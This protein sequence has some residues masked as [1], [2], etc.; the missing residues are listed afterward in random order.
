MGFST[1]TKI[2]GGAQTWELKSNTTIRH[3]ITG[4]KAD[5]PSIDGPKD[6][7]SEY[8][9]ADGTKTKVK[10]GVEGSL[11]IA[12]EE[13]DDTILTTLST[14]KPGAVNGID[15]IKITFT[16]LGTG[17]DTYVTIT[18][19]SAL[20]KAIVSGEYWKMQLTF[21]LSGASSAEIED[22]IVFTNPA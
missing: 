20:E 9:F 3:T 14:Y 2:W 11:T 5:V 12:V 15:T 13:F 1:S 21:T 6:V 10:T 19:I 18:G 8:E 4:V 7:F 22:L 17:T 16:A